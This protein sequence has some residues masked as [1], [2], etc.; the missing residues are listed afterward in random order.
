M[1]KLRLIKEKRI[2][3]EMTLF[4]KNKPDGVYICYNEDNLMK[5]K[6]MIIG[7]EDTPYQ[8][9]YYFF[10]FSIPH[11]YPFSPPKVRFHSKPTQYSCHPNLYLCGTVCLSILN[12]MGIKG[13]SSSISFFSIMVSI[14]SILNKYPLRNTSFY[15]KK[16]VA[17]C[18]KYN[19]KVKQYN[20]SYIRDAIN[21]D[22]YPEFRYH[23][24]ETFLKNY[25]K[26]CADYPNENFAKEKEL[27]ENYLKNTTV[28]E[29]YGEHIVL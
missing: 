8:Y 14:Q 3:K 15:Q 10:E 28:E 22:E 6:A 18:E 17:E 23:I 19:V 4:H 20:L 21:H 27:A 5:F 9:G 11:D 25:D 29:S 1:S 13:W 7:P 16:P 24:M 2:M 12:T 26:I